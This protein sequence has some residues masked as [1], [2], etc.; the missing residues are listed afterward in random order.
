MG[1]KRHDS[2][3]HYLDGLRGWA[4]LFVL[5]FHSTVELFGARFPRLDAPALGP[6]N[7]GSLAVAVFFVLSGLALSQPFLRTGDPWRVLR[8]AL[9]RHARLAIP[10]T[11]A[12]FIALVM[13]AQGWVFNRQAAPLTYGAWLGGF[14]HVV[15][16][17]RSWLTFSLYSALLHYDGAVSYGPFLWTMQ[18]EFMGSFLVLAILGL[19][20]RSFVSRLTGYLVAMALLWHAAPFLVAFV[21]GALISEILV[22]A[23]YAQLGCRRPGTLDVV[24]LTLILAAWMG[25]SVLR[26]LYTPL[27]ACAV[28]FALVLGV[29]LSKRAQIFLQTPLSRWLGRISFP[30]YLV[31]GLVIC[32]P[33]SWGILEL[34][35]LGM[36]D[37]LM[38]GVLVP[39]TIM[40]SLIAA[41]LFL[42]IEVLAVRAS[43]WVGDAGVR[44]MTVRRL[45][46]APV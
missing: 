8:M 10:V 6:I 34:H 39:A 5:I 25:S 42:P 24:G 31:H 29:A 15:P 9:G 40:V 1:T 18:I 44:L 4:S 33:T 2:R 19:L 3:L 26:T 17:W 45:G 21:P 11:A 14:L 35:R 38:V 46:R 12:S 28:A 41:C 27:M 32:G 20:G 13:L 16:A 22:C 36:S 30:L 7:D 43:R 23:P 37:A